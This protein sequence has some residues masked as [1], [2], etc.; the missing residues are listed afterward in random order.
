MGLADGLSWEQEYGLC[1]AKPTVKLVLSKY[2]CSACGHDFDEPR[3]S[4]V[5][6][7]KRTSCPNCDSTHYQV[8]IKT[9]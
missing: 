7:C 9:L 1:M 6:G 3:R 8:R 5:P 4:K 2:I